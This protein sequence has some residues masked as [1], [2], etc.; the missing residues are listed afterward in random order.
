M[1]L[2]PGAPHDA[3]GLDGLQ[4]IDEEKWEEL[5]RASYPAPIICFAST[6]SMLTDP[7]SPYLQC[8]LMSYALQ[9]DASHLP[10]PNLSFSGTSNSFSNQPLF[11]CNIGPVTVSPLF[12]IC[13]FHL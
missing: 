2:V 6:V 7:A 4:D 11:S 9:N 5:E 12:S 8:S 10:P 1:Y 3:S 13:Y